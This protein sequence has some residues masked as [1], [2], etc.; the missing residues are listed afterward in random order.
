VFGVKKGRVWKGQKEKME[1][2]IL[3]PNA[4]PF[5]NINFSAQF[6]AFSAVNFSTKL[7]RP[8]R[9]TKEE[10]PNKGHAK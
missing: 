7:G 6:L 5:V 8:K 10:I 1:G 9:T 4:S 3:S 2:K